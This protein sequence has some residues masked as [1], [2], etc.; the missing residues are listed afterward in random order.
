M[1]GGCPAQPGYQLTPQ[2]GHRPDPSSSQLSLPPNHW[3]LQR[4]YGKSRFLE[5]ERELLQSLG[6][7]QSPGC[8]AA[9]ASD[10]ERVASFKASHPSGDNDPGYYLHTTRAALGNAGRSRNSRRFR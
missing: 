5:R 2:E 8:K 4:S 9:P 6:A 7:G 3:D 1:L 10:R